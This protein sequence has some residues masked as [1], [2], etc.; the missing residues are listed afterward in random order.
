MG[1]IKTLRKDLARHIDDISYETSFPDGYV[2]HKITKGNIEILMGTTKEV[3][4][5]QDTAD[6]LFS[7]DLMHTLTSEASYDDLLSNQSLN[8]INDKNQNTVAVRLVKQKCVHDVT[9]LMLDG[10]YDVA[11]IMHVIN[12]AAGITEP[13]R[14]LEM[15]EPEIASIMN[16]LFSA[17]D[18]ALIDKSAQSIGWRYS[19]RVNP[20]ID[21]TLNYDEQGYPKLDIHVPV[22]DAFFEQH[23]IHDNVYKQMNFNPLA[24]KDNQELQRFVASHIYDGSK[25]RYYAA[26]HNTQVSENSNT[27]IYINPSNEARAICS[28]SVNTP[29]NADIV[30]THTKLFV[31]HSVNMFGAPKIDPQIYK[32][33]GTHAV[34]TG[35]IGG[36]IKA[37]FG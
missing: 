33:P 23:L 3:E 11:R 36:L 32:R 20:P 16:V 17:T 15:V 19:D 21:Y 12:A 5:I 6:S 25:H 27:R 31:H 1:N 2:V 37:F 30:H 4:E 10:E 29:I 13:A 26:T 22:P 8:Q 7:V 18:I 34:G 35:I 14:T 9:T 24:L 28:I